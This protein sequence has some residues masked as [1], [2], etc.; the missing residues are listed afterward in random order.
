MD[1]KLDKANHDLAVESGDLVLIGGAEDV[2]Q[3]QNIGL[4]FWLGEWF[5]NQLEGID[6]LGRVF[7]K[8]KSPLI[9]DAE[10]KAAILE[11]ERD[12]VAEILEY[13]TTLDRASRSL[14]VQYRAKLA[15]GSEIENSVEL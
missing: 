5:L 1:L 12:Q 2:A 10:I 3:S 9:R 15:D 13:N 11:D 14:L 8:G 7:G 4:R 6:F